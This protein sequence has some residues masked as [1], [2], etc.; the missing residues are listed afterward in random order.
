VPRIIRLDQRDI[1]QMMNKAI[2]SVSGK[3][4]CSV[5]MFAELARNIMKRTNRS[6]GL[7]EL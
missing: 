1:W 5:G 7:A 2:N 4:T 3:C 6:I